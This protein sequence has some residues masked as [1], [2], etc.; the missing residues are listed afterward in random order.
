MSDVDRLFEVTLTHEGDYRFVVD[1]GE[2]AGPDLLVDEPPPLG[3][4]A[5][6]N[7]SR[8]LAAAVG[9]CLA[10]S[11]L[12]CLRR[13]R[14]GVGSLRVVVEG[15]LARN[16]RGRVRIDGLSVRLEPELTGDE[17]RIDRCL[18]VFQDYCIVTESVRRGIPV[19]VQV[20]PTVAAGVGVW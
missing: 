4:S 2:G 6:P 19:E 17:S 20:R 8:M 5:G 16:S 7:A 9:N 13:A 14:V 15:V 3:E 10:A 1:F 11:L 12:F 18:E